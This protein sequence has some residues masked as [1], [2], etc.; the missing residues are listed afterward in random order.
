M[1]LAL[2]GPAT[3]APSRL[4]A[5]QHV[6]HS[7]E[8]EVL[9]QV[10]GDFQHAFFELKDPPRLVVDFTPIQEVAASGLI[11]VN[12]FGVERIRTGHQE[13]GR[14]RVVFELKTQTPF[15]LVN[16]TPEGVQVLFLSGS[17]GRRAGVPK[18]PPA[19]AQPIAPDI[20][21]L[22]APP[23]STQAKRPHTSLVGLGL[24]NITLADKRFQDVFGHR[25]A[26]C[27][28]GSFSQ[29]FITFRQ[30][31]VAFEVE[32]E[33][34]AMEGQS[35]VSHQATHVTLQSLNVGPSLIYR[36]G[37]VWPYA[38]ARLAVCQYH[39]TSPLHST[40][41]NAPGFSL[42][43]GSYFSA[44][45]FDLIKAR[46]FFQWSRAV[47]EEHGTKVNLG[48]ISIGAGLAL[49]FSLF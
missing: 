32:Y 18:P 29:A 19:Q 46:V 33:R 49:A 16:K 28:A 41:G 2:A 4:L 44:P 35:T 37:S 34:L 22:P 45:S 48:G 36:L 43:V 26:T 17:E 39:E 42:Q 30:M 47:A 15:Y 14:A 7:A 38:S 13:Q 31:A 10:E 21:Q 25:A 1:A 24:A 40:L 27:L 23:S 3:A 5:V 6:V 8:L 9:I 20:A 11:A 12:A